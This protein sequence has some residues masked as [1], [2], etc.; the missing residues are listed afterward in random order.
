M[1]PRER[2]KAL[3][4]R[5]GQNGLAV[6]IASGVAAATTVVTNEIERVPTA[7]FSGGLAHL[8]RDVG[9]VELSRR[10]VVTHSEIPLVC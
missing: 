4:V 6:E 5:Y 9:K 1:L 10:D 8:D 7:E 2:T 3:K